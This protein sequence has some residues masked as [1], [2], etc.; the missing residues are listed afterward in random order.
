[1]TGVLLALFMANAG[2]AW[3]NA[4]KCIEKGELDGERKGIATRTRRRS[5]ATRSATR[6]RTPPGPSMN[7]LIK[8]MSIVALVIAPLL[9]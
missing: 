5:S 2:G 7:I 4:K 9:A 8:L 6:S 3:D 1:M